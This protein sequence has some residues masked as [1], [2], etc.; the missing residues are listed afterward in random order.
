MA[1]EETNMSLGF[2][3]TVSKSD[4]ALEECSSSRCETS[5]ILVTAQGEHLGMGSLSWVHLPNMG[6]P[7]WKTVGVGR[8]IKYQNNRETNVTDSFA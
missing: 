1:S 5:A 7:L 2:N 4:S 8:H 6:E 3:Y